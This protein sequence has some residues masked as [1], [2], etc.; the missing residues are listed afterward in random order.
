[1]A[2]DTMEPKFGSVVENFK[3]ENE[4]Y[5]CGYCK[6]KTSN[7]SHGMWA[8]QI[9]VHDYQDLIDRGWRRSGYYCY[10]PT[11]QKICCPMYTIKCNSVDFKLSKSQ[12]KVIKRMNRF[13]SHGERGKQRAMDDSNSLDPQD[14]E[15][16]SDLMEAQMTSHF[17]TVD[18]KKFAKIKS[19]FQELTGS[20]SDENRRQDFAAHVTECSNVMSESKTEKKGP[21]V[22]D[23]CSTSYKPGAGPDKEKPP[24]KKAKLLRLERRNQKLASKGLSVDPSSSAPK[25]EN[26]AK[27]LED[28]LYPEMTQSPAHRLQVRLVRSQPASAEFKSS[29]QESLC[30][31]RRYQIAIHG[32][33]ESKCTE[34]QYKRFLVKSPLEAWRPADGSGPPQ[35]YGSF[36]QQYWLDD[37]LVAVGVL[38]I[39]PRCVSSVYF[40]YDPEYS[41]LTLGT[42]GSLREVAFVRTLQSNAPELKW[43]Y[44]GFYI[45]SC[46]K[47]RYKASL[48][49]SMLLCPETYTW[50]PI[51]RCLPLLDKNKYS[52]LEPNPSV[53]DIDAIENVNEVVVFH[54]LRPM[55]YGQYRDLAGSSSEDEEVLHYA[56]LVGKNCA[57]KMLLLR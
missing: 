11:M 1:M 50:H 39:L 16:N 49:P 44:M 29:F 30:V 40:Y 17:A 38:D 53:K 9:T 47:M 57:K 24:C 41:D 35:G 42:Y 4:G 22:K 2:L 6:S 37:K 10:K 48:S 7:Y 56:Q 31:Y 34:S 13:L 3:N 8:H 15:G 21:F 46:P 32:D 25:Q 51:E 54:D 26:F 12:K 55:Y 5:K 33:P 14:V 45:H 20:S 23:S 18:S 19:S 28:F 43:Y 36:H 52:R 27:K